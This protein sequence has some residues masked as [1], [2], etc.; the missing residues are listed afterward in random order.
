VNG[1][2]FVCGDF[3]V[4]VVFVLVDIEREDVCG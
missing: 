1:L 3:V 4:V 2:K